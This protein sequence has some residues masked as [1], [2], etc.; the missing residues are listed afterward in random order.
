[1]PT[2]RLIGSIFI[3]TSLL[4]T[5]TSVAHHSYA[6]EFDRD[7]PKTIEG[8]VTE[9]WFKSPHVRYYVKVTDEDG[10][11]VIWDTRGLTPVKLVRDGWLKDTIKVGDHVKLFGHVGHTNKHIMSILDVTLPDGR[12]LTSRSVAYDIK[13]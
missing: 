3:L 12:V 13:E 10:N 5:R 6:A 9:V 11:E 8:V 7:A 2:C 4:I 1:M